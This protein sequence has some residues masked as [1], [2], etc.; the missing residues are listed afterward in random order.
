M[1][2]NGSYDIKTT[3]SIIS[4]IKKDDEYTTTPEFGLKLRNM[5]DNKK[6][7]YD[8]PHLRNFYYYRLFFVDYAEYKLKILDS[9][10]CIYVLDLMN[11]YISPDHFPMS[12]IFERRVMELYYNA[13]AVEQAKKFANIVKN[14][15]EDYFKD[16]KLPF[17]GYPVT[18]EELTKYE[19]MGNNEGLYNSIYLANVVLGDNIE[20]KNKIL[21]LYRI[22]KEFS[23]KASSM[24]NRSKEASEVSFRYQVNLMNLKDKILKADQNFVS[25]IYFKGEK[26]K[27][28]A[29]A[30]DAIKW[31]EDKEEDLK[32]NLN[33]IN[34][35]I[36]DI[37]NGTLTKDI[38]NNASVLELN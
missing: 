32:E 29:I 8:E 25:D 4:N 10:G 16:P 23:Q 21:E 19:M 11:K 28:L 22:T 18:I 6:A 7:Y 1:K 14:T 24:S 36:E 38:S 17:I 15:C 27:A 20:A 12:L 9:A 5:D 35:M 26:D 33:I 2:F 37:K 31:Y 3:D 30:Q 34:K 13:G